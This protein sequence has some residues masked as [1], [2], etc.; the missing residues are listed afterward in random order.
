[1]AAIVLTP[2]SATGVGD[3]PEVSGE[4]SACMAPQPG[5]FIDEA[6]AAAAPEVPVIAEETSIHWTRATRSLTYGQGGLLEGQ[7]VTD[8]GAVPDAAVDLY[9]RPVGKKR[10]T[11]I[12]S[13]RSDDEDAVFRF[14]CLRPEKTTSYKV[15]HESSGL[16]GR[17]AA[18]RRI[19]VRRHLPDEMRQVG[20]TVFTLRGR[21][22]PGYDGRVRLQRRDCEEC[23]WSTVL[24]TATRNGTSWQFTF[25]VA[26][27]RGAMWFRAMVP[28]G[29]GYA[30]SFGDHVWPITVE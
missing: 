14:E 11:L 20:P 8:D 6:P 25:D 5:R 13:T 30:R 28:A 7:V 24:R 9:A 10:W 23:A 19:S 1:M 22:L 16:Y 26:A 2:T 29:D 17:S 18:E 27:R 3:D 21:V 15:V 4:A 12:A